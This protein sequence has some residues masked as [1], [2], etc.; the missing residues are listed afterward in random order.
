MGVTAALTRAA[1]AVIPR[2]S[3]AV[4]SNVGRTLGSL[5]WALDARHR[6][7]ALDNLAIA[8]PG[9]PESRRLQLARRAFEQTGRTAVEMLWSAS[10]DDTTLPEVATFEGMEHLDAALAQGHGVVMTAA[11][12]GNWELMGL[13][14]AHLGVPVNVIARRIDDPGVEAVLYRL[15]TRTGARVIYKDEAARSVLRTLRAGEAVGVLIDQ[16]TLPNQASFVPFFNRL[17]ATTPVAAQLHLRTGAPIIMFF[18][19]PQGDGYRFVIE[20]LEVAG[21]S[22][23]LDSAVDSLTAAATRQIE[24]H[25]RACPEAWLWIHDRWRTRPPQATGSV[26]ETATSAPETA[27]PASE[28]ATT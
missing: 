28:T 17:A 3:F 5:A 12:F 22:E 10:L 21:V 13:A 25:I 15:R 27:S 23:D 6:Q 1:A 18:S 2:L 8:F 9:M 24:R 26:S 7:V 11:H 19:V 14:L 20:P 16:N 4:A